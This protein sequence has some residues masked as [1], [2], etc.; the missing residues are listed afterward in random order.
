VLTEDL[1]LL[2]IDNQRHLTTSE[3]IV[4][5]VA[6]AARRGWGDFTCYRFVTAL[7][8]TDN[9]R[10]S[11]KDQWK[12]V[13]KKISDLQIAGELAAL[14]KGYRITGPIE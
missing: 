1:S 4:S 10:Q 2:M 9:L 7:V 12:I 5:A 3:D 8:M 14:E 6:W 13:M 11:R